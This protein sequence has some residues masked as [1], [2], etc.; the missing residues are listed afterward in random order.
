MLTDSAIHE[1]I[2]FLRGCFTRKDLLIFLKKYP[3][4]MSVHAFWVYAIMD[5]PE[6]LDTLLSIRSIG[7]S[8]ID[9][10]GLLY[11]TGIKH[12]VDF[13]QRIYNLGVRPDSNIY[14]HDLVY[15]CC[16]HSEDEQYI[17]LVEWFRENNFIHLGS[18]CKPDN[19]CPCRH[20][21]YI[22]TLYQ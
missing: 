3:N 15:D 12:G 22:K 13:L 18:S 1:I 2:H 11:R 6:N 14:L 4:C 20:R 8:K 19:Q 10:K 17:T 9:K 16:R 5:Y 7:I 21:P